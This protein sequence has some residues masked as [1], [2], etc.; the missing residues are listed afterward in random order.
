MNDSNPLDDIK[1]ASPCHEDWDAMTGDG[2]CRFCSSCEKTVY[3]LSEMTRDKALETIENNE[4]GLC[5]R[6]YQRHDGTLITADCPVGL[7]NRIRAT[8]KR[9]AVLL[10]GALGLTGF[11]GCDDAHTPTQ[12]L[13]A[14]PPAGRLMG[15]VEGMPLMGDVCLPESLPPK[16]PDDQND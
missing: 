6:V 3:N 16:A 11:K 9:T 12:G 8:L 1:I 5:V 14:E 7:R 10:I 2:P 15:E 4:G 13:Q